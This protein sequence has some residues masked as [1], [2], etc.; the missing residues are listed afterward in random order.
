MCWQNGD[1]DQGTTPYLSL[2]GTVTN[3]KTNKLLA[4]QGRKPGSRAGLSDQLESSKQSTADQT[5]EIASPKPQEYPNRLASVKSIHVVVPNVMAEAL[6][7]GCSINDEVNLTQRHYFS[8][9]IL[10]FPA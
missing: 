6:P 8:E 10:N 3:H 2:D 9:R 1:R 4:V 5:V 7:R